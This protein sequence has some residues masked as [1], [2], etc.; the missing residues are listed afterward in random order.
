MFAM[1]TNLEQKIFKYD[2]LILQMT[3]R[4]NQLKFQNPVETNVETIE[5]RIDKLK[6]ELNDQLKT[7]DKK[8]NDQF[9]SRKEI[10]IEDQKIQTS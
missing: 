8:F 2:D 6:V 5:S 10:M 1:K 3:E 7:L 4:Y 9:V